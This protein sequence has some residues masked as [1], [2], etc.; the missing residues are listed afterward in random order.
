VILCVTSSPGATLQAVC[1]IS[2]TVINRLSLKYL[3]LAIR[4]EQVMFWA[5]FG[6]LPG[7]VEIFNIDDWV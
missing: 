1:L 2:V 6:L 5:S 4:V 3:R 7:Y